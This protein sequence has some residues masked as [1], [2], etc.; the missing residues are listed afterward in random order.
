MNKLP[1]GIFL[2]AFSMAALIALAGCKGLV[3]RNAG[4]MGNVFRAQVSANERVSNLEKSESRNSEA[5]L[6]HIGAW[7]EGT[8]YALDQIPGPSKEIVV[9]KDINERVQ[10]LAN[11][12]DFN[13][14]REVKNIIDGLLSQ[15]NSQQEI[16]QAALLEK[17]NNIYKLT[18]EIKALD[19]AKESE[20]GKALKTAAASAAKADQ[21]KE[22]LSDMDSFFGFGA[23]FYGVKKLIMRSIWVIGI[24]LVVFLV[25]RLAAGSNPVCAAIFGIFE[26]VIAWVINALKAVAPKAAKFSNLVEQKVFDGYKTTL[27]KVIDGIQMLKEKG[28]TLDDLTVELAKSMDAAD[29]ERVEGVKK[30]LHWK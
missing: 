6:D 28:G 22:T 12:P 26:Q 17:D 25:L 16:A 11:K 30:D 10:T 19:N 24:F 23:I 14:V 20:V 4:T 5:R 29:K 2:A 13:E 7:S 9:A 3:D 18:L 1:I 15:M 27:T 8:Q 21:Y